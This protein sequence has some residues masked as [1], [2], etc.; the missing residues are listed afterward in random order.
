MFSIQGIVAGD[1][2]EFEIARPCASSASM[3]ATRP[4]GAVAADA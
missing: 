1:S 4:S 3:E 2:F